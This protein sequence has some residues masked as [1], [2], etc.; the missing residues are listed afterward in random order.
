MLSLGNGLCT[1]LLDGHGRTPPHALWVSGRRRGGTRFPVPTPVRPGSGS[2]GPRAAVLHRSSLP[3]RYLSP[4]SGR[5]SEGMTVWRG[6]AAVNWGRA[7]FRGLNVG[8]GW[9]TAVGR[10]GRISVVSSAVATGAF[11]GVRNELPGAA[12]RR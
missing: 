11:L 1:L 5:P 3:W 9:G 2:K 7:A 6:G 4:L 10:V 12:A 8:K